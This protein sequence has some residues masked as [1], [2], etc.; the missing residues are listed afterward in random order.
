MDENKSIQ[1]ID[2]IVLPAVTPDEAKSVMKK[3]SELKE[4]IA[5][6]SDKQEIQTRE[7]PKLF[8][9][10]SYWRKLALAFNLTTE[11][12][13]ETSETVIFKD[14]K[15]NEIKNM[16]YHF[17]VKAIATNGRSAIGTGSCDMFEK[18]NYANTIHNVRS[19][20]ETRAVNRAISNLVGGGEVS[21]EEM[22][23]DSSVANVEGKKPASTPIDA[24]DLFCSK[25]N[26]PIK[27]NVAEY[28]S[29]KFGRFLC[30]NCQKVE[31]KNSPQS[32]KEANE[33]YNVE[34][35]I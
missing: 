6:E 35:A 22:Q 16:V 21:A 30:F 34:D 27:Q 25:C 17:L 15:N 14:T 31:Q 33:Q 26:K 20:A 3:Y 4:A 1:K 2:K 23:S 12:V 8:Y 19:T 11:I 24:G 5:E 7:G 29:V 18:S 13:Q 28:S 10:K 32:T 9:K